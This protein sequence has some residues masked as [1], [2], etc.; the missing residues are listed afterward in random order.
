[1]L[2]DIAGAFAH[3]VVAFFR[4]VVFD[5]VLFNI[6]RGALLA[7]TLGRYPRGRALQRDDGLIAGVGFVV[8][9]GVALGLYNNFFAIF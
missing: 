1:M 4:D 7:C 8:L 6:G 3:V 9:T 2:S 5:F